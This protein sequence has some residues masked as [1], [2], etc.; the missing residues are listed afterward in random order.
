LDKDEAAD[1][2]S[3]VTFLKV[4]ITAAIMRPQECARE[5]ATGKFAAMVSTQSVP[6]KSIPRL[7]LVDRLMEQ[8]KK[9]TVRSD[10]LDLKAIPSPQRSG[11]IQVAGRI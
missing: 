1:I 3:R 5:D 8:T 10:S 7:P 4:P 11:H 6:W 9:R 2:L